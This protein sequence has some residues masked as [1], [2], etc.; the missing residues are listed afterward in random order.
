[1]TTTMTRAPLGSAL[2]AKAPFRD[3]GSGRRKTV[4]AMNARRSVENANIYSLGPPSKTMRANVQRQQWPNECT[5]IVCDDGSSLYCFSG[6]VRAAASSS[7]GG[8]DDVDVKSEEV[9]EK[10]DTNAKT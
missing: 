7:S 10:E 1:M 6:V 2:V 9:S 4:R 3:E 8:E 5:E